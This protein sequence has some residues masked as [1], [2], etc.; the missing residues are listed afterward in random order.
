MDENVRTDSAGGQV[1]RTVGEL[2][3]YFDFQSAGYQQVMDE[4]D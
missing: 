2:S 3:N 1:H 4:I